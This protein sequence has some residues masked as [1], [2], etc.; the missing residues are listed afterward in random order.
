MKSSIFEISELGGEMRYLAVLVL[1]L[2]IFNS[3]TGEV[4]A[5]DQKN[6]FSSRNASVKIKA[7]TRIVRP[8]R[9]SR[10]KRASAYNN[11]GIGH[12]WK[13][14]Y[15]MAIDDHTTAIRLDKRA[16]SAY[17]LRGMVYLKTREYDKAAADFTIRINLKPDATAYSRRAQAYF[18][19][20]KL[21]SA[22]EDAT[23]AVKL[24]PKHFITRCLRANIYGDSGDQQKALE[25]FDDCLRPPKKMRAAWIKYIQKLLKKKGQYEGAI[26]GKKGT[27]LEDAF[28]ACIKDPKCVFRHIPVAVLD[29]IYS[30]KTERSLSHCDPCLFYVISD[31]HAGLD[32]PGH[33]PCPPQTP[34]LA[35]V[36]CFMPVLPTDGPSVDFSATA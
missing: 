24:E 22:L 32:E 31:C 26:N 8:G 1:F 18:H 12:R 3:M 9:L 30:G 10:K 14:N 15:G 20:G 17:Q 21:N 33:R 19:D 34:H 16:Y 11:R 5:G 23:Q 36:G 29:S 27:A 35:I 4:R 6:C 13:K 25:D 2:T 28:T 7:C